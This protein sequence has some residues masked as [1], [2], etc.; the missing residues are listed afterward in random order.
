MA[1]PGDLRAPRRYLHQSEGTFAGVAAELDRLAAAGYTVIELM[2]VAEFP[3]ERNWGYDGVFPF[4]VQSSY[5]GPEGLAR[6]CAEAHARGLGVIVDVVY[7]HIGPGR[8]RPRRVRPLL[9]R[10][11]PDAVGPAVNVDGAGS[12]EVRS[13]LHRARAATSS[14]ELGVDGL[15]LDAVHEIV[16][17]PPRPSSPS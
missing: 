5:G 2:P 14:R 13:V 16:D 7:N 8:G 11:L 1:G 4:A 6:C 3:G 17:R 9:H 15:R 10:P 12:D